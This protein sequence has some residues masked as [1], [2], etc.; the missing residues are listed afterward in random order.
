MVDILIATQQKDKAISLLTKAS[1]DNPKDTESLFKLASLYHEKQQLKQ[2]EPLYQQILSVNPNHII[3]LNN[4]AWIAVH[5]NTSKAV[6]LAKRAY[7]Q[8]PK[9]PAIA[10]TY[11]YFLVKD[12]QHQRGLEILQQAAEGLPQD[13]DIQYHL[14]FAYFKTGKSDKAKAILEKIVHAKASFSEQKNAQ[15]LLQGL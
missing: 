12:G 8:E 5:T 14:S 13:N 9:S 6:D 7:E 10:D 3:A 4:L 11:G 15:K 1:K 2:A